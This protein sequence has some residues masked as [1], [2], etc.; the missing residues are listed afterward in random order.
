MLVLLA[1]LASLEPTAAAAGDLA[2]GAPL[3]YQNMT[4]VPVTTASPGP[5]PSY[6]LLEEGIAAKTIR[7]R[8]LA[9]S[10][11]GASVNEV[12]IKNTGREPVFLLSGEMI[13][14]GKQ[15]RILQSDA[16][17]PSNGTW[18]RVPVFCVEHGRWAGQRMEF[19]S[20]GALAHGRLAEAALTGDQSKVW[21]EVARKNGVEGTE[22][23]T[24]TY[25]R[26]VQDAKLRERIARHRSA[27]K[28]MLPRGRLAGF[29]FAI[30]GEVRVADLFGNPVLLDE[31]ADKLISAYVLEALE[32]HTD[33]SAPPM[34]TAAAAQF[35]SS[36]Q[37]AAT[38]REVTVGASANTVKESDE[39]IANE[40]KDLGN[41]GL[42]TR[43]TYVAKKKKK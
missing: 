15:D 13:L 2:F 14:G 18:T 20:G 30:N 40:S 6:T 31:L 34:S 36:G 43:S 10:D 21:A 3:V 1:L 24:G 33:A 9:G 11:Q 19:S 26:T 22:N 39:I 32:E 37:K 38:K 27:I 28:A 17:I 23:A 12:E 4:L 7:V 16:I 8:E 25:R 42:G 29:V 35:V 41:G 5:F